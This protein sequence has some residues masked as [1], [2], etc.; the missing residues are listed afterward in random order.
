MASASHDALVLLLAAAIAC[1]LVFLGYIFYD[2]RYNILPARSRDPAL[3]KE[4]IEKQA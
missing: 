1:A 4:R 2:I 3:R